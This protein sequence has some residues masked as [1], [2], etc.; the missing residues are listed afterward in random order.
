MNAGYDLL[1]L[2][3]KEAVFAYGIYEAIG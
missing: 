1:I 3:V 2:F